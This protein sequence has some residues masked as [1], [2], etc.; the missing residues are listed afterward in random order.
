[1]AYGIIFDLDGTLADTIDDIR[2]A[3]NAMLVKLGYETRTKFEILQFINNGARELVRRSLPTAIQNEELIL[4]SAL[5]IYEQEYAKAFCEKTRPF[6]GIHEVLTKLKE[7]KFKL[8][9]LSNKQDAFVKTIVY[10]L[11]GDE[12]F[13][14]VRGQ[15]SLPPKPDPASANIV[16]KELGVKQSKCIFVGDSDVDMKTATNAKMRPVGVDWGY[17]S[18]ELLIEAGANYIASSPEELI[19]HANEIRRIIIMEKKQRRR[20]KTDDED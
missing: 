1:M 7:D 13:D 15:T 6:N 8:A 12:T 18:K 5:H 11:F 16:A 17:R 3:I 4:E 2:N 14:V 20:K 19:E 10:K 9:V